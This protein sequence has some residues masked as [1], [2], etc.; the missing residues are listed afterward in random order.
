M[1]YQEVSKY[2]TQL[3]RT[4]LNPNLYYHCYEHTQ[5]VVNN[6]IILSESY[7]LSKEESTILETAA[8][9]HDL[10]FI[11]V[12]NGHEQK[13]AA[14]AAKILPEYGYNNEQ[15][16]QIQRLIEVTKVGET[17]KTDLE[18]IIVDSDLF[19]L[20][21]NSFNRISGNLFK[22]WVAFNMVDSLADFLEKQIKF[23][24]IHKYYT[25]YAQKHLQPEKTKNVYTVEY[26]LRQLRER[27]LSSLAQPA[28]FVSWK[29]NRL[30]KD[31]N[32]E[33]IETLEKFVHKKNYS[34]N[35][36]IITEG[37]KGDT[38]YLI[39][40]GSVY[41]EKEEVELAE[42][43]E[44]EFFGTMILLENS[45]RSA[46]AIA[47]K[48]PTSIA[49]FKKED[50]ET[51]KKEIDTDIYLG[52]LKNHMI[53]QQ[54]A[55]RSTNEMGVLEAKNYRAEAEK[56]LQFGAFIANIVDSIS[57]FVLLTDEAMNIV[58]ANNAWTKLSGYEKSEVMSKPL[59]N[60]IDEAKILIAKNSMIQ[61]NGLETLISHKGNKKIPV[62]IT[63]KPVFKGDIVGGYIISGSDMTL[64]YKTREQLED[65]IH[66]L[67]A[68]NRLLS[69][70]NNILSHDLQEPVRTINNFANILEK[71]LGDK[72][73]ESEKEFM[74][75]IKSG[76]ARMGTMIKALLDYTKLD[77]IKLKKTLADIHFLVEG[78]CLDIRLLMEEKN[79]KVELDNIKPILADKTLL[80]QVLHNLIVNAIKYSK[81]DVA[82]IIEIQTLSSPD[83]TTIVL[84]DN[85][86]G[87]EQN[88]IEQ[89]FK[90]FQRGPEKDEVSGTGIGLG[91]SEKIVSMHR[92]EIWL[93][94]ELGKGT[95][96]YVKLPNK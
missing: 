45:L 27:Q 32:S 17:P 87:I 20:G 24:K 79:A 95:T 82:P 25:P 96:F 39:E 73:G 8:L 59:E 91:I 2:I 70:F 65:Y 40:Q 10:G 78:I 15:I 58:D 33:Q 44:G 38:I 28:S 81:P 21:T 37:E 18:K 50:I 7:N 31:L 85:G 12:Y 86:K 93:E 75:F 34:L 55:L 74:G 83:N 56:S 72:L 30:L 3:L 63:V 67:K 80:K 42:L 66:D 11:E 54:E 49:F 77:G 26:E 69:D 22:E 68:K 14:L 9:M 71:K 52:I 19:Y 57:N 43:F 92:G 51:I 76:A 47:A 16:S 88:R 89:I 36:K 4:K 84:K 61:N 23:L 6:T 41:I 60:F 35:E 90:L 64:E 62:Q 94:S 5:E 13:G 53:A 48:L 1:Q 29:N 46:S